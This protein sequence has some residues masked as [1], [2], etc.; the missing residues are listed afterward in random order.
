MTFSVV[1]LRPEPDPLNEFALHSKRSFIR[2]AKRLS[3][4]IGQASPD[5]FHWPNPENLRIG[6]YMKVWEQPPVRATLMLLG[7]VALTYAEYLAVAS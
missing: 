6:A 7:G 2:I 3:L 1:G 5:P 4:P